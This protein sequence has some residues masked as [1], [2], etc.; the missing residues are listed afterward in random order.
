[1]QL[2]LRRL[3]TSET[4]LAALALAAGIAAACAGGGERDTSSPA[5]SAARPATAAADSGP[6]ARTVAAAERPAANG[7]V[8]FDS[9]RFGESAI[10]DGPLG[11]SVRRGRALLLH[12]RDSLPRN[13]GNNLRCTSCHL[14]GGL[15]PNAAPLVGVYARFPQFRTRTGKVAMLEERVNDCFE[16]SMNGRAIPWQSSEMRD[17][18]AYLSFLSSGI[19]APGVVVGQGLPHLAPLEPDTARGRAIYASTCAVCHGPDGGGIATNPALWGPRSYNIGASMARLGPAAGFI[20]HNMPFDRPGTLTDQQAHDVAAYINSHTRPDLRGKEND[21]P[22]GG[23]PADV[24]YRTRGARQASG[25][26]D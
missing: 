15:R 2:L 16:R 5:D 8:P 21:W 12:T 19:A 18:V 22:N 3:T 25:A 11:A 23:A 26:T 20:R 1:M 24:P 10:P 17:I 14:D 7:A 4:R 6:A 9:A 13:V